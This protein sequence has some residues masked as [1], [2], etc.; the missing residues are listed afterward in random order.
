MSGPPFLRSLQAQRTRGPSC[1]SAR[2]RLGVCSSRSEVTCRWCS[3]PPP[4]IGATRP[5]THS[6]EAPDQGRAFCK[7]LVEEVVL[8][9]T[10]VQ[11][12]FT[13]GNLRFP[14]PPRRPRRTGAASEP[15]D[16]PEVDH[17]RGRTLEAQELE[18]RVELETEEDMIDKASEGTTG[19]LPSACPGGGRRRG[20]ELCSPPGRSPSACP[21]DVGAEGRA[22][23]AKGIASRQQLRKVYE[24]NVKIRAEGRVNFSVSCVRSP[25][26]GRAKK[27][28]SQSKWSGR[29][30]TSFALSWKPRRTQSI[31]RATAPSVAASLLFQ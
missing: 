8:A 11:P 27:D 25:I 6:Q 14:P 3:L 1:A 28:R 31:R 13:G 5:S 2:G 4:R 17:A 23:K 19:E 16:P 24:P 12:E 18:L 20:A 15:R 7:K 22:L 29:R 9:R 21:A 26:A 10:K 30:L